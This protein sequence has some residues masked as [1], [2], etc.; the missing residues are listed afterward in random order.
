VALAERCLQSCVVLGKENVAL[1]ADVGALRA[2]VAAEV[3]RT[4]QVE[5]EKSKMM[6]RMVWLTKGGR[7]PEG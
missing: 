1:R 7:K 3:E 4:R 2:E 5:A 6:Q